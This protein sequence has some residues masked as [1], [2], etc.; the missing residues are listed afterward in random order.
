MVHQ[1]WI[2]VKTFQKYFMSSEQR[3]D[4]YEVLDNNAYE[5]LDYN[6]MP[7]LISHTEKTKF[8][9]HWPFSYH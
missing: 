1:D 7:F 5:L 4:A 8:Y 2:I 9:K 3:K 6:K